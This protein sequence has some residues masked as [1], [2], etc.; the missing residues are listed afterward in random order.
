MKIFIAG[1]TGYLGSQLV[2]A[3]SQEHQVV[4]LLRRSSST[5]RLHTADTEFVY[6]DDETVLDM[7]FKQ[8][9]PEIVINTAALYGRKGES[10]NALVEANIAFPTRLLLLANKYK[11]KLFLNTGTSLPDEI[12]PYAF[13]KNTFVK[14]AKFKAEGPLKFVNLALEHFYGPGDDKSKFISFVIEMC[15][16]GMRLE[17]TEG[18]QKR[19]FIF[20]E[21]VVA[22]F[23]VVIKN[24]DKLT[25]QETIP[26][27]TGRS[28][29]VRDVVKLIHENSNSESELVFGAVLMRKNELMCSFAD[30]TRL[31]DLGWQPQYSL[32]LGIRRT[33]LGAK[34]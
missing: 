8:H 31:L 4:T 23:K 29:T 24:I 28:P 18:T 14:L 9:E 15:L 20:I 2:K 5:Q 22:S 3:L 26:V 25:S 33:L 17:L 7:A 27:G 34:V 30:V 1:A 19:D 6:V 12:S 32:E 11:C 16:D 10:L 13:T 21:D